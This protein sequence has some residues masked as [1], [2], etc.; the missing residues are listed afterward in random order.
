MDPFGLFKICRR[1]L[2]FAGNYMSSGAT[3]TNLGIFHE[4]G[5]YEDGTGDNT[6]FTDIGLFD[7]RQNVGKYTCNNKS[8]DDKTMRLAQ[9]NIANDWQKGYNFLAKNCQD[10]T[11]ALIREF[12]KIKNPPR[13][14]LTRRGVRCN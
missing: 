13:C 3:G 12:N 1:P 2:S 8:Y 7:D 14:R 4:H 5:F 10:Y 6:G 9:K 11:D